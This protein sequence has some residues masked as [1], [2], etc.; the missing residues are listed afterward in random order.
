MSSRVEEL[1]LSNACM[2]NVHMTCPPPP[3]QR[4]HKG[5]RSAPD[6]ILPGH[7][8]HPNGSRQGHPRYTGSRTTGRPWVARHLR[9][10]WRKQDAL[11]HHPSTPKHQSSDKQFCETY[12]CQKNVGAQRSHKQKPVISVTTQANSKIRTKN[13]VSINM[14]LRITCAWVESASTAADHAYMVGASNFLRDTVLSHPLSAVHGDVSTTLPANTPTT[15]DALPTWFFHG[16]HSPGLVQLWLDRRRTVH[17]KKP[18][19]ASGQ[20]PRS[21]PLRWWTKVWVWD[22]FWQCRYL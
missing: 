4:N 2:K 14:P 18:D 11:T 10:K 5:W 1:C 20:L 6:A 21:V 19:C 13:S 9:R 8:W 17:P 16:S 22:G 15:I 3:T 12:L 7:R